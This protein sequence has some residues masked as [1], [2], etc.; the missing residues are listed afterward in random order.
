M[1][2][3]KFKISTV[4]IILIL[5]IF[6]VI[7][8]APFIWMILTSFKTEKETLLI[9]LQ[10]LPK[11]F[12]LGNYSEIF[13]KLNFGT[14]YKNTIIV[15]IGITVPQLFLSALA[16][17]AFARLEF[18]GKNIIFMVLMTALMVPIQ[19]ILVPRYSLMVKFGWIDTFAGVIVPSVP[20]IYATFFFRQ[21]IMTIPKELDES[22]Y[23]DGCSYFRIFTSIL[24][25]LCKSTVIAMGILTFTFGW[26]EFL[27]PLIVI[28]SPGKQV[29]SIAIANFR[30]QYSTKYNL[31]MTASTLGT[32]PILVV[33]IIGQ[34]YFLEGVAMSGI[35]G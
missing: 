3:R 6:V 2:H 10:W 29:L 35:K 28:N 7:M 24:M 34:R 25:P 11:E 30:G 21:Q 14:Y 13:G 18:P 22:A 32:L 26:N 19:M 5:C 20:S 4:I 8:F 9:P 1:E 31:L 15:T 23:L 16:A 27:W 17:Y 33:F 12:Y